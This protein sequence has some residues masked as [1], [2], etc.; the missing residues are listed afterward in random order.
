MNIIKHINKSSHSLIVAGLL[1]MTGF[2]G[3]C[4]EEDE[5]SLNTDVFNHVIYETLGDLETK[6]EAKGVS[7]CVP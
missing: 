1:V 4:Q 6:R 3:A 2:L 7:P 5:I